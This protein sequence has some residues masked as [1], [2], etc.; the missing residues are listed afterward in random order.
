[1]DPSVPGLD[2]GRFIMGCPLRRR[3]VVFSAVLLSLAAGSLASTPT[4]A[5]AAPKVVAANKV[6]TLSATLP[7]DN[8]AG[9][10]VLATL[11]NGLVIYGACS[12]SG[13]VSLELRPGLVQVSS[14]R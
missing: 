4:R 14:W 6:T 5:A 11:D 12:T 9:S 3:L 1:M 8:F 2:G 7:N 13:G 10:I